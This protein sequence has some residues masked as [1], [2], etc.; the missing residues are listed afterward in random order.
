MEKIEITCF[1]HALQLAGGEFYLEAIVE[2]EGLVSEF[3]NS[4]L[5]D[6]ALYN[7]G[8]C[9]YQTNQFEEAIAKYQ[10]VIDQYPDSTISELEGGNEFGKTAAKCHYSIIHACLALGDLDQAKAHA[11]ELSGFSETHVMVNNEKRSYAQLAEQ[12]LDTYTQNVTK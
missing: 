9:Y 4:E 12:A 7:A 8:L 2:F 6:D 3:P 10:Q 11:A 1:T 5:A